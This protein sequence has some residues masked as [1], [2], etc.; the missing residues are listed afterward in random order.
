MT[1]VEK[2]REY[3]KEILNS[4]YH[5]KEE[6]KKSIASSKV[7]QATFYKDTSNSLSVDEVLD[8][9]SLYEKKEENV[10]KVSLNKSKKKELLFFVI[11]IGVVIILITAL[12]IVGIFAFGG[13]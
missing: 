13:N 10:K 11:M 12:I 4:F 1:R 2:Y 7:S 3:R 9:Y 8:A 5:E 6:S